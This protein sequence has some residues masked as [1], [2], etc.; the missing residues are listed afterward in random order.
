MNSL[1]NFLLLPHQ[2][3][4]DSSEIKFYRLTS[5]ERHCSISHTH[6]STIPPSH[7]VLL[8]RAVW[9]S[10]ITGTDAAEEVE[11]K[12]ED[13][14]RIFTISTQVVSEFFIVYSR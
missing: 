12:E 3:S 1:K 9:F 5:W 6:I 14:S 11:E 7:C 13:G 2:K 4:T 8:D 10:G